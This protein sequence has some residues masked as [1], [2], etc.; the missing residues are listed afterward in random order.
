MDIGYGMDELTA[1]DA[2][3]RTAEDAVHAVFYS[4]SIVASLVDF[5][6]ICVYIRQTFGAQLTIFRARSKV[7]PFMDAWGSI[8]PRCGESK[9][10]DTSDAGRTI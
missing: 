1:D 6:P 7:C 5:F 9:T 2:Y 3:N 4:D 8:Q 10:R